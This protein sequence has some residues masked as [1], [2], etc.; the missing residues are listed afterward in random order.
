VNALESPWVL[1]DLVTLVGEIGDV[2][3]VV[4]VP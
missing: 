4:M 3:S 2:L 1:D